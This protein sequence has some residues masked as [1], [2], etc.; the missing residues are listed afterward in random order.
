L[1]ILL[2][3]A[4]AGG[5]FAGNTWA[6][7]AEVKAGKALAA[8]NCA[9]CHAVGTDDNSPQLDVPPL[10][11]IAVNYDAEELEDALNEGVPTDHPM[12]PDWQM[13]PDQ[14]RALTEYIMSIATAGA[15]KS[16]LSLPQ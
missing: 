11:D 7:E 12:M 9:R 14:A 6:G 3:C 1:S 2:L 4:S 5:V 16:E 8:L 15:K 13:T 10:R